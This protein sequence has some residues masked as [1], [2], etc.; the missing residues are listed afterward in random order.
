[1]VLADGKTNGVE[2]PAV[3]KSAILE[4][5]KLSGHKSGYVSINR[6]IWIYANTP[7]NVRILAD[8]TL[9]NK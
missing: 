4:I 5:Y 7:S 3:G 6:D 9:K 1:M 2:T 8:N